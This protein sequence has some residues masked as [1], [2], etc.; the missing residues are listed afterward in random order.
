[1]KMRWERTGNRRRAAAAAVPGLGAGLA[2]ALAGGPPPAAGAEAAAAAAAEFRVV[3]SRRARRADGDTLAPLD[4]LPVRDFAAQGRRE[5]ADMLRTLIPSYNV[6]AQPINSAATLVRPANLR[7]LSPDQTLVLVNGKRW[8]RAAAIT[9]FGS[10]LANGAQGPDVGAIPAIA[11]ERVEVLRDGASAQYGSDAIAGV[12]NFVLRG[13]ADGGELATEFGRA[14]AGDGEQRRLAASAGV[15]LGAAG[16]LRL[17]GEWLDRNPTVRSVQRADA[18][19]LI[20]AGNTAVEQP[21]AQVWGQPDLDDDWKGFVN[22]AAALGGGAEFYAFGNR[23]E[24]TVTGGF[25]FRSPDDRDGV[26]STTRPL[27]LPGGA[28][29]ALPV[30]LVGDRADAG[31][32]PQ[33]VLIASRL[34]PEQARAVAA[35]Y[36]G[37]SPTELAAARRRVAEDDPDCFLF[38]QRFPGGFRP[39]FGGDLRDQAAVAGLRGVLRGGLRYDLSA[40]HGEHEIDFFM[41][42]SINPSLGLDS[43]GS[44]RLGAYAQ[45]ERGLNLDLA[46]PLAVGAFASPLHAAAGLEWREAEFRVRRGEPDSWRAGP[47]AAQGFGVGANGFSGFGPAVAGRWRRG[48]RARYLDLEADVRRDLTLGA[49]LRREDV[50]GFAAATT[51]KLSGL[52]RLHEALRLRLG[53]HTGFRAPTVGQQRITDIT[54][55]FVKRGDGSLALAQRATVRPG[56]PLARALGSRDLRPEKSDSFTVGLLADLGAA[57]VTLDYFYIAVNDRVTQSRSFDLER[58]VGPGRAFA[59]RA[60]LDAARAAS[61]LADNT[62]LASVRYFVNDFDTRTRGLDLTVAAPLAL[63]A[64]GA[65]ELQLAAN[66]TKTRVVRRDPATVSAKRVAQLER[67]LPRFR[68]HA[69]L[70]HDAARWRALARVNYYGNA[71]EYHVDSADHLFRHG[72]EVTLDLELGYRPAAG[73]ELTLGAE[74]V[75]DNFPD[76]NPYARNWGSKYA[77]NAPYGTRGGFYYLSARREF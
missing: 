19:A 55:A 30:R 31:G 76:R 39:R 38:N 69:A 13:G 54:T 44:F 34:T 62:D 37:R 35:A 49:A 5:T 57:A 43:P 4:I 59:D 63:L 23:S 2:L 24:R 6:S 36:P 25:Y 46:Y 32:C 75:F 70:R 64:G 53:R 61:G 11:L 67:S 50:A 16:F 26:F 68:A 71:Q 10:G 41:R 27:A 3:G 7:G 29:L 17:S 47:Y 65:S 28:T 15:P 72:A 58:E 40:S 48:S 1:M 56:T 73:L 8:H 42:R 33:D 14:Y 74:N 52:Y 77:E 20:D 51:W 66:W 12:L 45:T 21:Y 18:Q 22:L 60:A 9:F